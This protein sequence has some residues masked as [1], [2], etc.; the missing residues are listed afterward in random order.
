[1]TAYSESIYFFMPCFQAKAAASKMCNEC[2]FR[3]LS[4][5]NKI[6]SVLMLS[7]WLVSLH[8]AECCCCGAACDR[9]WATGLLC[10]SC[11]WAKN[12]GCLMALECWREFWR[13]ESRVLAVQPLLLILVTSQKMQLLCHEGLPLL[14]GTEVILLVALLELCWGFM[15]EVEAD[16]FLSQRPV[17]LV[18][19]RNC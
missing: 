11:D 2:F 8:W 19:N 12:T 10:R 13:R 18:V 9:Y 17:L 15:Q 4:S 6:V 5:V 14:S 7:C 1:M 16:A 3:A